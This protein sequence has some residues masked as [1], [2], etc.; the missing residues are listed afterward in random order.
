MLSTLS[1]TLYSKAVWEREPDLEQ[2]VHELI[3]IVNTLLRRIRI[4][5]SIASF[6]R[7][8]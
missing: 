8:E 3:A 4:S 6:S 2:K 7:T 5:C 1:A